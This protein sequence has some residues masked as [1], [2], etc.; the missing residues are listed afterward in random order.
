M[1]KYR[2]RFVVDVDVADHWMDADI[3]WTA[4]DAIDVGQGVWDYKEVS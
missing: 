3:K 2:V 4:I 1:P